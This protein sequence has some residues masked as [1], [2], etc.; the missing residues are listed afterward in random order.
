[1]RILAL[2]ALSAVA[3]AMPC[4]IPVFRY[5]LERWPASP[6]EAVVF[7]RGPLDSAGAAALE[8]LR[9]DELAN[10]A[11]EA[12]DLAGSVPPGAEKV[13]KAQE[14][15]APPWLVLR[16]PGGGPGDAWSGPFSAG[17]VRAILDS[18]ARREIAKRLLTGES[19]VWLLLESGQEKADRETETFITK[20]LAGLEKTL[21]LPDE[22]EK[23]L[24]PGPDMLSEVPLRIGFSIL[25]VPRAR[26]DE[27]VLVSMLLRT[28]P[29]IEASKKP[30]VFPVFGR[31]RALWALEGEEISEANLEELAKFLTGPCSCQVKELN[32]GVDLLI[33]AD[34][35][36]FVLRRPPE[37]EKPLPLPVLPRPPAAPAPE[38]AESRASPLAIVIPA[39]AVVL[40]LVLLSLR[41]RERA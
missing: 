36:S 1:M 28:D 19:A 7:H 9:K 10:I 25:R 2:T 17:S 29:K 32:P 31:G 34:W 15:A 18:P 39:A 4:K 27:R 35:N 40:A 33:T 12:I 14:K 6:Y 5:A 8:A 22:A 3:A 23:D 30:V 20:T 38:E 41:R 21:K 16:Y 26:P 37:A 11:V 24:Q 13:W